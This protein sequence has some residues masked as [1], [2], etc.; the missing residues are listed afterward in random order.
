MT[1]HN[2]RVVTDNQKRPSLFKPIIEHAVEFPSAQE[3]VAEP[4]TPPTKK[5]AR[6]KFSGFLSQMREDDMPPQTQQVVFEQP[7]PVVASP[8]HHGD[9]PAFRRPE[10]HKVSLVLDA[11]PQKSNWSDNYSFQAIQSPGNQGAKVAI[12]PILEEHESKNCS[13]ELLRSEKG[14]IEGSDNVIAVPKFT[15]CDI[16]T[17][18]VV[19]DFVFVLNSAGGMKLAYERQIVSDSKGSVDI[20]RKPSL[21]SRSSKI[22]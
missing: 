10:E 5:V 12:Q 18:M 7:E 17:Y 8:L 21:P 9:S 2:K 19:D 20:L 14:S 3:P 22:T 16:V 13:V 1:P 6:N 4:P 11:P 15:Y